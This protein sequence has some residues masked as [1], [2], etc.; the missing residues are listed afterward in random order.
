MV[1]L[2]TQTVNTTFNPQPQV[3][4]SS[5]T[6]RMEVPSSSVMMVKSVSYEFRVVEHMKDGHIVKVG[7]Q[8]QVWEHDNYG[9]GNVKLAW[10]DVK[11]VQKDVDTGAV[12][13][14]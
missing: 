12:T 2:N 1:N 11:R 6:F 13:E 5:P 8:Y 14:V 7:L 10:T 4:Q 3:F 9:T